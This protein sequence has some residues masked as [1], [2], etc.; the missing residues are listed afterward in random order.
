MDL[1]LSELKNQVRKWKLKAETVG[2]W[3]SPG[4]WEAHL[5]LSS[6]GIVGV[7]AIICILLYNYLKGRHTSGA[8]NA[9]TG[10]KTHEEMDRMTGKIEQMERETKKTEMELNTMQEKVESLWKETEHL[11]QKLNEIS[12]LA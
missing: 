8:S 10:T 9:T 3:N 11:K 7:A 1:K 12:G 4:E 5:S 2:D 6:I